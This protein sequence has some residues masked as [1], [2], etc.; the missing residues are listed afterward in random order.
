MGRINLLKKEVA[1]WKA[2]WHFLR[3]I[4]DLWIFTP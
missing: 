3:N 4:K 2:L 1:L